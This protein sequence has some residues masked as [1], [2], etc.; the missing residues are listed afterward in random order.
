MTT[1]TMPSDVE[2]YISA[3]RAALADLPTAERDD[4]LAEVEASLVESMGEASGPIAARLGRP[5]DFAAELRSAAGLHEVEGPPPTTSQLALLLRRAADWL[6]DDRRIFGVRAVATQLAPLWWAVR[7]YVAVAFLALVATTDWSTFYPLVPRLAGSAKI[8]ALVILLAIAASLWL[9]LRTR[10][11]AA[12]SWPLIGL[13]AALVL[14]CLPLFAEIDDRQRS[15]VTLAADYAPTTEVVSG[16]A[17]DGRPILNVYPYTRNGELLQD[18]LLYDSF[19]L[20]L[21]VLDGTDPF[22]RYL[23]TPQGVRLLNSFPIRYVDPQTK[24]VTRP[25]AAPPVELPEI[26]TPAITSATPR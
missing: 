23:E 7:G 2:A 22:R 13:N 1:T 20:P 26:V 12:T 21:D 18:V 11:N 24:V 19:G 9:G 14:A 16:L 15:L 17:R 25:D 4:L 5:E 10:R 8:G 3:V 6:T